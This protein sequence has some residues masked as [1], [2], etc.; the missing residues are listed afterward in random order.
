MA[1]EA[2]KNPYLTARVG[3]WAKYRMT[4]DGAKKVERVL[5]RT[6]ET[7]TEQEIGVKTEIEEGGKVVSSR[8]ETIRLDQPHSIRTPSKTGVVTVNGTG[9]EKLK[10]AGKEFETTW[11]SETILDYPAGWVIRQ[12][13]KIWAAADAPLDGLVKT[14]GETTQK[15]EKSA[16]TIKRPAQKFLM[17]LVEFGR[18]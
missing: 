7:V 10:A 18:K 12:E 3:D 16:D 15:N 1:G 5:I 13:I 8:T 6:V 11:T 2:V 9:N 14:E 17:E 4:G